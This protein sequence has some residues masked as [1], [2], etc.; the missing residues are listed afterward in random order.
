[1]CGKRHL[2][3]G[4]DSVREAWRRGRWENSALQ[5]MAGGLRRSV[6]AMSRKKIVETHPKNL[7]KQ[8]MLNFPLFAFEVLEGSGTLNIV[9]KS[10]ELK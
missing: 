2:H 9:V 4:I 8:R 6:I 7:S 1:M 3:W 10:V 5:R